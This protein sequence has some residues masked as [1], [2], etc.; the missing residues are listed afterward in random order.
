MLKFS[1]FLLNSLPND[2]ILDVMKLKAFADDKIDVAQMMI[3]VLDRLQNIFSVSTIFYSFFL[4][5]S[6]FQK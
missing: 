1:A 3:S 5:Q 6:L 2:K 4:F